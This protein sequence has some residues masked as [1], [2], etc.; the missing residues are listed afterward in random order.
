MHKPHRN[1]PCPCGS[2][3]KYKKCHGDNFKKIDNPKIPS[4]EELKKIFADM[5]KNV[6]EKEKVEAIPFYQKYNVKELLSV[7]T[8]LLTLPENHGKNI[9]IE[10]M[11]RQ[12]ILSNNHGVSELGI[13]ELKVFTHEKFEHNHLEDPPE[14][15]FTENIMTPGGN[16]KIFPGI[17]DGQVYTL[18]CFLQTLTSSEANLP[19]DFVNKALDISMM[20][21][22]VSDLIAEGLGYER[23]MASVETEDNH[24]Y[25]PDENWINEKRNILFFSHSNLKN[26]KTYLRITDDVWTTIAIN[27]DE[28]SLQVQADS[29]LFRPFIE[30]DGG[31]IV[32]GPNLVFAATNQILSLAIEHDCVKN[33]IAEFSKISL[34]Y[35]SYVLRKIGFMQIK[36]EFGQNNLPIFEGLFMFDSDKFAYVIVEYDDAEGYQP[37]SPLTPYQNYTLEENLDKRR[38]EIIDKLNSDPK[39]KSAKF[40]FLNVGVGIGRPRVSSFLKPNK[41]WLSLGIL[42]QDLFISFM[43]GKLHNLTFW[44]YAQAITDYDLATPFF[45]D[46]LSYFIKNDDTFYSSDNKITKLW[47]AVG[48]SQKFRTEAVQKYDEHLGTYFDKGTM[49]IPISREKLPANLPVY[50]TSRFEGFRFMVCSPVLQRDIWLEPFNSFSEVETAQQKIE[51]EICIAIAYWLSEMEK[52]LTELIPFTTAKP[53]IIKL[54]TENVED[55]DVF[56]SLDQNISSFD[57]IHSDI[58][59]NGAK[60]YLDKYFFRDLYSHDNRGEI[61]LMRKILQVINTIITK[62]GSPCNLTE[63][64]ISSLFSKHMPLGQKKKLLLSVIGEDIRLVPSNVTKLRTINRFEVNRQ[65]DGL[66]IKICGGYYKPK[67]LKPTERVSA[68]NKAVEVFY[69]EL[70]SLLDQFNFADILKKLFILHESAIQNREH[71]KFETAARL[72]CFQHHVD[73]R[74]LLSEENKLNV[75]TSLSIRCLIEHIVA[76]PPKGTKEFDLESF[77]KALAYMYNIINWGFVSDDISFKIADVEVSY[78]ESGRLGTSKDFSSEIIQP[79]Y[80]SKFSEDVESSKDSFINKFRKEGKEK[81]TDYQQTD[82]DDPFQGEFGLHIDDLFLVTQ[83]AIQIA[84]ENRQSYYLGLIDDFVQ[85]VLQRAKISEENIK[86]CISKFSLINRGKVENVKEFGFK[87]PDFYPWRYNRALSLLNKPFVIVQIAG[88]DNIGFSARS[89]YDSSGHILH[90][91]FSGR[92]NAK[93]DG[94]KSFMSRINADKGKDFNNRAF[95]YLDNLKVFSFVKPSIKIGPSGPLINSEDLGDID[96]LLVDDSKKKILAIECKN[97]NTS[98]TP[99][100]IHLEL[101]SFFGKE[102]NGWISKVDKRCEW[103]NTNRSKLDDYLKIPSDEY[104]LEY[105]FLT[106]QVLPLP[107]IK[108]LNLKYRFISESEME[109]NL[110]RLISGS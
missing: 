21:L 37:D 91:F 97:T 38:K 11:I 53:I 45:L 106:A 69:T 92:Y 83:A 68:V 27:K 2:G 94:M 60:L 4:K 62:E 89:V 59:D 87:N 98:R 61:I 30:V 86:K 70:R 14:N 29:L 64:N 15:L 110:S 50:S 5:N 79:F 36:Y 26:L 66:A 42:Y 81:N 78:L 44:N 104:A 80:E 84:F 58:I 12:A 35:C 46:N 34:S 105:V 65:L 82:L 56:N 96:I 108:E 99:Y 103:L 8:L 19:V 52:D 7:L 48:N 17:T 102:N 100:E 13:N 67:I 57:Q 47:I 77:D 73:I 3:K 23:N 39:F 75:S 107:F 101:L 16:R 54:S 76:E 51:K 95:V 25:F 85:A 33:F 55:P 71:F 90:S 43:S 22:S 88:K 28:K 9:R 49:Y 1:D 41:P 63:K 93:S 20:I 6:R 24:I 40:L 72:A 32:M 31:Y 74:E 10:E 109:S 18:Q